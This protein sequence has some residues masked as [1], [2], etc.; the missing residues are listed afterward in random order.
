VERKRIITAV[1][2]EPG[3]AS[4][5]KFFGVLWVL[6]AVLLLGGRFFPLFPTSDWRWW[7]RPVVASGTVWIYLLWVT[8]GPLH[9]A[10]TKYLADRTRAS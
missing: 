9:R 1:M 4:P 2:R 6:I 5:R 10:V 8:N 3:K 7:I